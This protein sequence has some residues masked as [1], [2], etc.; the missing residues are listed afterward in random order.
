MSDLR[1]Q[2]SVPID[3]KFLTSVDG[4]RFRR[5]GPLWIGVRN[6]H[7]N[8]FAGRLLEKKIIMNK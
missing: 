5:A 4:V 6:G 3:L 8:F 1:G 7:W 2:R